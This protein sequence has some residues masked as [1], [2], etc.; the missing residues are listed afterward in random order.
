M[1]DTAPRAVRL[2]TS[3][4]ALLV[5]LPLLPEVALPHMHCLPNNSVMNIQKTCFFFL[6][7]MITNLLLGQ[8]C[9]N[10]NFKGLE[11]KCFYDEDLKPPS[12]SF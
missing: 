4:C 8:K 3:D 5:S 12:P 1:G 2:E 11:G 7:M 10:L 6:F 9:M